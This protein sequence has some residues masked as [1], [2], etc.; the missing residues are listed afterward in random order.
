MS[1]D[2]KGRHGRRRGDFL[3]GTGRPFRAVD[4]YLEVFFFT[5]TQGSSQG[6]FLSS[7][8]R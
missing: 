3:R 4:R 5:S 8:F 7:K 1:K 6:R 2:R